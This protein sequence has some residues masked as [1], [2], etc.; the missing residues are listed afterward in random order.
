MDIEELQKQFQELQGRLAEQSAALMQ[1]REEQREA[2]S[3][4]RVV[5]EKQASAERTPAT[6]YIPRERKY[7]DFSGCPSQS[8]LCVEEWVTSMQSYFKV[9]KIPEEDQV[10]LLKQHLKGEAK[11]TVKFMLEGKSVSARKIFDVLEETY[12][13]KV[14]IGTRL[15]EFYDRK[16]APGETI[17]G[18]AYDL[19]EKLNRVKRRDETRVPDA[20]AMLKEQLV[21]G[22][23]ED[24]LRREMKRQAKEQKDLTF[25]ALMQAAITWSE[26][27]EGSTV[28]PPRNR[29]R[30]TVN[31]ATAESTSPAPT[32]ETLHEAIQGL[33]ARQD[34]LFR[35]LREV[36]KKQ[37]TPVKLKKPPLKDNEGRLICY[38]CGQP[39][40]TSRVCPQNKTSGY[41]MNL[42]KLSKDESSVE[43]GEASGTVRMM[44]GTAVV[45][46]QTASDSQEENSQP[47]R[48][49]AVGEC[50]VIDIKI[51][52]VEASCLLDTGSEVTTVTESYF[53]EH[54]EGS[55]SALTDANW[56]RL[57]AANGLDIPVLGCL[58]A[59]IQC[60][61]KV[62]TDKC[63]FVL[64][65]DPDEACRL[66]VSGIV[67]MN[68]L[69]DLPEVFG[70]AAGVRR[71]RRHSQQKGEAQLRRI[72]ADIDRR[73]QFIGPDGKI[74]FVKVAGRGPVTIPARSEKIIEGRCRVPV[75][76]M[77]QV[78]VEAS[79]D[80]S[81][82]RGLLVANVLAQTVDGRV[83]VRLLNS[84]D[85]A[86]TLPP[87]ARIAELCKPQEV[88]TKELVSFEEND[89]VLHVRAMEA[90]VTPAPG[91]D[92]PL[93]VPVQASL[94]GLTP[95]QVQKLD[96]L[97]E[98][99]RAVFSQNDSD[100][101][102][103]T[104]VAH[105]IQTGDA[106]PIKQRHRRVP[107]HVFQEFKRH[108]KDLVAQGVLKES[109]SPWASPA[110]IVIKKD[111]SVRF[112]CDY[113]RLNSV[114]WKDAYPLP[115]VDESLDALGKAQL[116]STLDLTAGYFQVAVKE[117]DQEKTAVTTPFG[118][119]QWTRMPFGL[120]N[121]PATFQ[122]LME[123]ALGDLAFDVLL[124]YLDDIIVF[125]TDFESHCKRLDLVFGRLREHGLKLKPK[126]CFLLRTEVKFLGHVISAAGI[127]VD[128]EKVNVLEDWPTPRNVTE[129]RQLLGFMG[130]YRRFVP[131]FAQLARPLHALV[132]KTGKGGLRKGGP[133]EQFVW[134][135]ECQDA[136]DSLRKS[137]MAP[138][139][140]AYP[141]FTL[142]FTLTTD[143]SRHGLGAVLSQKQ[144]GVERVVA[145][146]SR[147]LRKT[148]RNDKNY[149]AFKLELLALKWAITE[150]FRDHLLYSKF[151]V[152]TDHNPLRYLETANLG[153]VEQRWVAQ[154]AEHDFEVHYKPGRQNTNADVLSRLPTT[155]EPEV[156]DTGKD[157]LVMTSEEVRACL[158]PA[159]ETGAER[160]EGHIAVQT[161]VK[162]KVSGYEWSE[163]QQLQTADSN[164][165]PVLGAVKMNTRPA[166]EQ[167]QGMGPVLK[168]LAYQWD[169][170][171]I[172]HG[173]L[174]R[175]IWDPRDGE[176]IWQLVVPDPLQ[177]HVFEAQ[178]DHKGHFSE[179][180]TL[181]MMRRNYYWPTMS[182]DVQ[183]W[184]K[185]C[186]RCA[187]AKDVFPKIRAPMT[188]TNVTVPLE[189]LAMDYT[190]LERSKG[191]YENVLVLTDMFTRFTIAVPTKDQTART[192]A[193]ALVKH[194]FVYYGCP[195][196][197]HS[198][199]GRS[200]EASV[201]KE[202]CRVYG[203]SKSRT[204]PYHPQG[205]AQCERFNR[206]MHDMLRALPPEKKKDWNEHLPELVLAYNSHVHSSTGYSPFYLLFGRDARFPLDVL[207]GGD[208]EHSDADN[209]DDWVLNHHERLKLAAEVAQSAAKEAATH[210]K[211]TYDRKLS[212]ALLRPGDRVLMRNHKPRGRNKIQDK[213]E[214]GPYLVVKQNHPDVPVFTVRPEAGGHTKVVHREQLKHCT[215]QTPV[216][217]HSTQR[218]TN[219][220]AT[221]DTDSH[222]VVYMP[223]SS[224]TLDTGTQEAQE[225]E[226]EQ[227][228]VMERVVS[229]VDTES[230]G[231]EAFAGDADESEVDSDEG[232]YQR[233]PR[234]STRGVLPV[235]FRDEY[236]M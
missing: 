149:S 51:N 134:T 124:I 98:K 118:L 228:R 170:L 208:L 66:S 222:A 52:G 122:R 86:I 148:E 24:S 233:R 6:V 200:F 156:E 209:L 188:C 65:D 141:D 25:I 173:V 214:P 109:S 207:G 199:Q 99:H 166:R 49:G 159:K 123:V 194:W 126:K 181:E 225:G 29:T 57:T 155:E 72:L 192:T 196:R 139:V 130:Y 230:E 74:G 184:I 165:C 178:H 17:R 220:E 96:E 95:L 21:L 75:K 212:A 216:R 143:G 202:L 40:H 12:G 68:V 189:V 190:L 151:N 16:Q 119:F 183:C 76:T 23:R 112:C 120:C 197:L 132:G 80:T 15:R 142:P 223:Q 113:R 210:R 185:Q 82:P 28:D 91:N 106:Q 160:Q 171:K 97:L 236:V 193:K 30:G 163:V 131:N 53:K 153:A 164:I 105:N 161:A 77:C 146:A 162:G 121:A 42:V 234:R 169:R 89:G 213:W 63:V 116:F 102:Y 79:V 157:F 92:T 41:K 129:V 103:T 128:M 191:G 107:P 125:S 84:S 127:Q 145:F 100:Y 177:K 137:L 235:R 219:I 152:I 211:R 140:L 206:T 44:A 13:D 144:D 232:E 217:Q 203:I 34:E 2:L 46:H 93:S 62:F 31:A 154:L 182:K 58:Q 32:L 71:M 10:E 175:C 150:K 172:R 7:P 218:F 78:L 18:Y 85:K 136:F 195:S 204:S 50:L 22:L 87:R 215:F 38:T 73:E 33:A 70:G 174:F 104:T 4:A 158:W 94:E 205:N 5:I 179:K 26:E 186:R 176:E 168:K 60:M 67:G 147:G 135:E 90:D 110:V 27:E 201:I 37:Q 115:R 198:D 45:S 59:D 138:P 101:G 55:E 3:L 54:F 187:L 64:R 224:L 111:G 1:A 81:L 114:T 226:L 14:P 47:Q 221:S 9:A 35:T 11:S 56:V 20:E 43:G 8:E 231:V 39:G 167:V 48:D 133:T 227:R 88:V 69:G 229:E 180:G 61:G 36:E 83:P 117:Q 19:Q 108:V